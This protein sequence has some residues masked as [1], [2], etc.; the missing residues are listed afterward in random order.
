MD[1]EKIEGM[2]AMSKAHKAPVTHALQVGSSSTRKNPGNLT[3]AN[4]LLVT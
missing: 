1:D 2:K 3:C 4:N